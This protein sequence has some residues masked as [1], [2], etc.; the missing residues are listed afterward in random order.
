MAA[1]PPSIWLPIGVGLGMGSGRRP[2][3]PRPG[4]GRRLGHRSAGP[5]P[6]TRAGMLT[7]LMLGL[8]F[9]ESLTLFTFAMIFVKVK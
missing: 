3:R 8:A 4:Q 9:I 5:Q 2:L 7:F 1:R 6:G